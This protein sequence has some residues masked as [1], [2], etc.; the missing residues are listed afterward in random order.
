MNI[1]TGI[2]AHTW[3]SHKHDRFYCKMSHPTGNGV[4][5]I[6]SFR[7]QIDLIEHMKSAHNIVIKGKVITSC[8]I[9]D[10]NAPH[11]FFQ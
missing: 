9:D 5:L 4:D 2:S 10:D 6:E 8:V 3:Y 7:M 1:C 11:I